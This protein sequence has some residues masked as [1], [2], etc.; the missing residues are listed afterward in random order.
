M[1][2]RALEKLDRPLLTEPAD[3]VLDPHGP[4][5][6]RRNGRTAACRTSVDNRPRLGRREQPAVGG[7]R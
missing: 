2:S 3:R 5:V 7:R 6:S 1:Q 4:T